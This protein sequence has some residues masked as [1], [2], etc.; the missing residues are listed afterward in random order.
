M[1]IGVITNSDQ[2]VMLDEP[3][4]Y[5]EIYDNLNEKHLFNAHNINRDLRKY[6]NENDEMRYIFMKKMRLEHQF[7]KT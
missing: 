3:T 2:F 7:Y 5:T 1:I 6:Q 4:V